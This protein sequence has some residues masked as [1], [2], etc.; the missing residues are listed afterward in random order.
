MNAIIV[1]GGRTFLPYISDC[2]EQFYLVNKSPVLYVIVDKSFEELNELKK[3]YPKLEIV[4]RKS[5]KTTFLH[6]LY[7]FFARLHSGW[8]GGFWRYVVERFFLIQEFMQQ[9]GEENL[10]HFEYDNL[11]YEDINNFE[12]QFSSLSDSKKIL[13]PADGDSRC[14]PGIVFIP[15]SESLRSFCK[16]YIKNCTI[17]IKNDM[18]AFS[19]FID[20]KPNLCST[21]PVVPSNYISGKTS[22]VSQNGVKHRKAKRLTN[23]IQLFQTIFDAAALGQ[24]V[25]GIDQRAK[26]DVKM[27]IG[28]VNP[29]AAYD[30][31]DFRIEWI[32]NDGLRKPS[33][34]YKEESYPIFNLHIHSKNLRQYRSDF[35]PNKD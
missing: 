15:N 28:Y 24:Y 10:L 3:K 29:D 7:L 2:I 23:G 25:G 4:F 26:G 1:H 22:L 12:I 6:K 18:L 33:L 27:T 34:V 13:L 14:I 31:R 21:L 8:S 19:D 11:I 5:L 32:N 17:H 35:S 16:F 9:T 20:R 30:V